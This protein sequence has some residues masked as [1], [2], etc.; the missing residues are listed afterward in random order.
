MPFVN[1]H[2]RALRHR[3]RADRGMAFSIWTT[4]RPLPGAESR[5]AGKDAVTEPTVRVGV[6]VRT[7]N[8]P[9]FLRRAL[10]DVFAQSVLPAAVVIVDDGGDAAIVDDLVAALAADRAQIVR[11][12]HLTPA[13]GRAGAANAGVDA[14]DTESVVLHDDDDLWHPEFLARTTA[15]LDRHPEHIGVVARTEIVY[16]RERDGVFSPVGREPMWPGLDEILFADLLRINRFVP[17]SFLYRRA[18]HDEVGGYRDDLDVVEDWEFNLRAALAHPIGYLSGPGGT[19]LAYWMQRA[20]VS[21][22]LGNSVVAMLG[23][24]SRFDRRVRD[25]GLR[26]WVAANGRGLPLYLAGYIEEEISRQLD[27]RRTLGQRLAGAVRD[28]RRARRAR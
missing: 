5:V 18:L 2:E 22:D 28:W 19:A 11:V 4:S 14:L 16:E 6:V 21:G 23:E 27:L 12:I 17:I 15:W 26:E 3:S 8:R 9:I 10:D 13:R 25:E 20:G 24:H 1:G 7:R